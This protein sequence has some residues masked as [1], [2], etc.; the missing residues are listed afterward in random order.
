MSAPLTALVRLVLEDGMYRFRCNTCQA[1]CVPEQPYF[2]ESLGT[3]HCRRCHPAGD[4][5]RT[6]PPG[7]P[8]LRNNPEDIEVA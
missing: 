6:R 1:V 7:P 2:A 8:T 4:V 5:G 3:P